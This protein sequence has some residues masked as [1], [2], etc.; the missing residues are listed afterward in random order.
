MEQIPE[1]DF[2]IKNIL[3]LAK[4]KSNLDDFGDIEYLNALKT[5]LFAFDKESGANKVGRFYFHSRVIRIL[6]SRLKI[7]NTLTLNPE[8][9]LVPITNPLFII[10]MLRTGTTFLHRLIACDAKLNHLKLWQGLFPFSNLYNFDNNSMIEEA[11]LFVKDTK[12]LI[13]ELPLIHDFNTKDAEEC[14]WLLEHTFSDLIF[15]LSAN[16]PS[17]SAWLT[18]NENSI[19]TYKYH[20]LLLQLLSFKKP[21][22]PWVLKAPRHLFSLDAILKVYPDAKIVWLHRDPA[23]TIPSLCSLSEALR[24]LYVNKVNKNKLG[25][26]WF[27]KMLHGVNKAMNARKNIKNNQIIDIK[28]NDLIENPISTIKKI[29]SHFNYEFS[30]TFRQNMTIYISKNVSKKRGSHYYTLQEFGLNESDI[31][32]SFLKYTH[33]Y[34]TN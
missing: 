15:E 27:K 23:K 9:K 32:N 30:E 33:N 6:T 22:K 28:Y 20:R 2:S 34:L 12:Q 3:K 13:K 19:N 11:A 31:K 29:Y 14:F 25:N 7:A 1:V 4:Q 21:C 8:I 5:L 18:R 26:F 16:I 24:K 17:Y 10:G